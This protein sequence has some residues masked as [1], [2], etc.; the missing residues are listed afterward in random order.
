MNRSSANCHLFNRFHRRLHTLLL[1]HRRI[2]T[3]SICAIAGIAL[4]SGILC[5]A[6]HAQAPKAT[7]ELQGISPSFWT[8][9]DHNAPLAT[10]ASGF[11]FTEGPVWD[12]AGYLWVSDEV[13]NKIFRIT[14]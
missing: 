6:V 2:K 11:V 14:L 10:V 3:L 13:I 12:K 1:S 9:V 5:T 8:L 7:F 4:L